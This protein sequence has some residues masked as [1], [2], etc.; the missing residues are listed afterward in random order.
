MLHKIS[1]TILLAILVSALHAQKL[2]FEIIAFNKKI[3]ETTVELKT[4][5]S[6]IKY[7]SLI[8]SMRV[9]LLFIDKRVAINASTAIGKDG[10]LLSSTYKGTKNDETILTKILQQNGK[11]QIDKNGV[12]SSLQSSPLFSVLQLY[13]HEPHNTANVFSERDGCFVA[14]ESHGSN[15]Y[16]APIASQTGTYKYVNGKLVEVEVATPFGKVYFKAV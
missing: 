7:Y 12:K 14:I 16:T 5:S 9:K 3:G 4:D 10:S 15:K 8:S 2:K 11:L 1:F 6:G 13:F